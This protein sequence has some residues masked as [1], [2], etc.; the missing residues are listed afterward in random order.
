[1]RQNAVLCG[2]GLIISYT[3]FVDPCDIVGYIMS[4]DGSCIPCPRGYY[5]SDRMDRTCTT[6]PVGFTTLT[7]GAGSTSLCTV[8]KKVSNV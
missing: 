5:K 8:G 1:M 6:C 7:E 2:N 4:E 3:T